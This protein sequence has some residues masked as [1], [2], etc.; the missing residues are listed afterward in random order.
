MTFLTILGVTEILCSFRLGL[1]GKQCKKEIP[2]FRKVFSA[3]NFVLSDAGGNTSRLLNREVIADLP[4]LRKMHLLTPTLKNRS[5]QFES[6]I[7][8]IDDL[9]SFHMK[10]YLLISNQKQLVI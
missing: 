6:I 7:H 9:G 2:E 10:K 8:L 3:N 5:M 1:E 4:L